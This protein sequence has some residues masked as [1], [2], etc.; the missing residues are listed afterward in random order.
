MGERGGGDIAAQ[1]RRLRNFDSDF[2][3]P[4]GTQVQG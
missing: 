1:L 3:L 2:A 4:E